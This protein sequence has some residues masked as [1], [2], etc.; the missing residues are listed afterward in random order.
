MI[1]DVII[2]AWENSNWIKEKLAFHSVN[3]GFVR[4]NYYSNNAFLISVPLLYNG[5]NALSV[6]EIIIVSKISWC[7]I[8]P[9][10]S[11]TQQKMGV[12]YYTRTHAHTHTHWSH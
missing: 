2:S 4:T 7:E 6:E 8:R 12:V 10:P 1:K 5:Q 9:F 3:L 11:S